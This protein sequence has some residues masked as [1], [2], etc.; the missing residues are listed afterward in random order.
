[1]QYSEALLSGKNLSIAEALETGGITT[2]TGLSIV[3]G[4]LVILMIM[5]YLFKVVFYKD[6]AK[7]AAKAPAPAEE[8]PAV[9]EAVAEAP[10]E[11][12][13]ELIAILTAA[14]AASLNTSTYNLHI[15]SYR[16]IDNKRPAWNNA[17]L[18]ETIGNRF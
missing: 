16:R 4:V 8:A 17:G 10:E 2:L 1:M 13:E 15:K 11:D 9:E 5:L 12:E 14:V 7:T 18:R 3:F 6:P